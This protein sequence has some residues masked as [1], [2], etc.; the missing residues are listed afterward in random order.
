MADERT[1]SRSLGHAVLIRHKANVPAPSEAVASTDTA[2]FMIHALGPRNS[3]APEHKYA[4]D[5]KNSLARGIAY[6]LVDTGARP[7]AKAA[8]LGGY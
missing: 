6:L 7:Y 1:A 3:A 5:D 8:S 2:R 4:S